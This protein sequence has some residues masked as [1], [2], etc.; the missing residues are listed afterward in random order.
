[1]LFSDLSLPPLQP[2]D[3]ETQR[4]EEASGI[5]TV[6]VAV[7]ANVAGTAWAASGIESV[8]AASTFVV[9]IAVQAV[10]ALGL[11][12]GLLYGDAGVVR[13]TPLSVQP[14]PDEIGAR[15]AERVC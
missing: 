11:L 1:M 10:A 6:A 14:V 4:G 8:A 15:L 13:R 7:S 12:L 2:P 9:L 5:V 3:R